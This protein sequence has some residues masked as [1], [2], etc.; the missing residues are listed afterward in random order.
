[1]LAEKPPKN[2]DKRPDLPSEDPGTPVSPETPAPPPVPESRRERRARKKQEAK[3]ETIQEEEAFYREVQEELRAER[4]W[5]VLKKY[6]S[7]IVASGVLLIA[8]VAG[9]QYWQGQRDADR[10]ESSNQ[11][12]RAV[13]QLQTGKAKDAA[14]SFA[15]IA[16]EGTPGFAALARLRQGA[17]LVKAGDL[18][19]AIAAY[20]A[21]AT[22]GDAPP[23][24]RTVGTIL[25]AL[26]AVDSAPPGE[27]IA[28]LKPLTGDKNPWRHLA[29]EIS[30]YY[31]EKAKQ[32]DAARKM[33]QSLADDAT[34]PPTIRARARD[35][36]ALLSRN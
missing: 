23:A 19:G 33:F 11:F 22:N 13:Q 35:M 7:W 20:Q 31:L 24:L 8:A 27:M 4:T 36:L 21:L 10:A 34:A 16:R 29:R 28:R 30:G 12:S 18:K 26:H 15:L 1:M 3:D 5:D 17:A 32:P 6:G 9:Y 14:D 2:D 25:W